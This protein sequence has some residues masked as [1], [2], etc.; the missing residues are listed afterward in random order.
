MSTPLAPAAASLARAVRDQFVA[1]LEGMLPGLSDAIRARLIE[2]TDSAGN[3]REM[4]E[5][6]D[7][8]LEFDRQ[9]QKWVQNLQ[10]AW[11]RALIPPT[12][13][14]RVRLDMINLELIGDDVVENKIISSRL[15]MA[16]QEIC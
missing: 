5:R 12:A 16:V 14:A 10:V 2:L 1:H 13:T 3:M 7:T 8:L 9:R 6:R 4:H 11:R 15:A